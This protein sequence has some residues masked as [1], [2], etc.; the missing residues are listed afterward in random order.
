MSNPVD[1][2]LFVDRVAYELLSKAFPAK[3]NASVVHLQHL[4][5][6]GV[7]SHEDYER[8]ALDRFKR[9]TPPVPI[10]PPIAGNY[11]RQEP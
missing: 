7:I 10:V 8:W 5:D 6:C 11:T 9:M 3:V 1:S 4:R 2:L